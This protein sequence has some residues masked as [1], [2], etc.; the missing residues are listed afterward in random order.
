MLFLIERVTPGK[1]RDHFGEGIDRSLRRALPFHVEV[2]DPEAR[3]ESFDSICR[4]RSVFRLTDAAVTMLRH[5]ELLRPVLFGGPNPCV[6]LCMGRV[7]E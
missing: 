1:I 2:S 3:N 7:V 6:C 5:R 4:C